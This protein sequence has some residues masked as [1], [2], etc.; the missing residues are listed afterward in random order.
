MRIYR[1]MYI[2]S[3]RVSTGA[4]DPRSKL[5]RSI[6]RLVSGCRVIVREAGDGLEGLRRCKIK[7][8]RREAEKVCVRERKRERERE[9]ED[10][11]IS[12]FTVDSTLDT[13]ENRY[14]R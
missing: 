6:I 13:Q 4:W 8:K 7:K 12:R 14:M 2:G 3:Q 5:K 1:Y 10:K 11:L 9:R